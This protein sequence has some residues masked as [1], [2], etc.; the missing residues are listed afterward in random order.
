VNEQI[1]ID[2]KKLPAE[3]TTRNAKQSTSSLL[4]A[5]KIV[6]SILG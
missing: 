6:I 4:W 1:K 5:E 2:S 3:K